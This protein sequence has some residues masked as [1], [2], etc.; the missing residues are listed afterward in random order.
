MT[1]FPAVDARPASVATAL[2]CNACLFDQG[3]ASGMAGAQACPW[4]LAFLKR[5][6]D[7][8][9]LAVGARTR[10]DAFSPGF[11]CGEPDPD[12]AAATGLIRRLS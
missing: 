7:A 3:D 5:V 4:K 1:V 10:C 8:R 6:A 11:A 12:G 9:R 2:P